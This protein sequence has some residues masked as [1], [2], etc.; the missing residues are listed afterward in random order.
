MRRIRSYRPTPSFVLAF[1]AL[2]VA[3]GG[4]ATALEGFDSVTKDDIR[5]GA[6]GKSEVRVDSIGQSELIE[7][8]ITGGQIIES[9]L[10]TVPNAERFGGTRRV[11]IDTLSLGDDQSRVLFHTGN[12]TLTARC[13][14][15]FTAPGAPPNPLDVADIFVS[16]KLDG[17]AMDGEDNVPVLTRSVLSDKRQLVEAEDAANRSAFDHE[18]D[19][20]VVF[21]DGG[22]IGGTS[23]VESGL[24]AGAN[25]LT[26]PNRCQFGGFIDL[27]TEPSQ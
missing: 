18:S 16:P 14:L 20:V 5:R 1:I 8:S 23:I 3:L 17:G 13:R 10:G 27:K 9:T 24:W 4:T 2:S 15:S 22:S 11:S 7:D 19:G 21:P 26:Q 25:V 6:V 12:F